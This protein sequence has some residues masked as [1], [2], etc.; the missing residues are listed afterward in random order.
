MP[1]E[2][3]YANG[4]PAGFH[5]GYDGATNCALYDCDGLNFSVYEW[6]VV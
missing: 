6:E 2:N 3:F 5:P 4:Q 1:A